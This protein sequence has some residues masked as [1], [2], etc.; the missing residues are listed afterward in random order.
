MI[1]TEGNQ[2]ILSFPKM[3]K[4]VGLRKQAWH[5]T[6]KDAVEQESVEIRDVRAPLHC[7]KYIL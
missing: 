6:L 1:I 7:Y 4:N 5:M 3:I 2:L